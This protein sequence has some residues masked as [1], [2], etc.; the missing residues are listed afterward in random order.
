LT[1]V[2]LPDR[3]L[4]GRSIVPVLHS[5]DAASPHPVFHWQF[6]RQW[7]VR[8]GNWKL[9]G[10]PV[11]SSNKAPVTADDTLFLGNLGQDVTEMKNLAREFGDV[12]TRLSGL[13]SEWTLEVRETQDAPSQPGH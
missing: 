4:D 2:P 8:E 7:A 10:N 11:D 1:G 6:D 3:R 12:V 9:I 5:S 13:H